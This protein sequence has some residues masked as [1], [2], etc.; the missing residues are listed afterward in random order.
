LFEENG[1][2]CADG[3]GGKLQ[4]AYVV[5]V[6]CN[7]G[8]GTALFGGGEEE[9]YFVVVVEKD[10]FFEV[11]GEGGGKVGRGKHASV[12][13]DDSVAEQFGAEVDE[14]AAAEA[15]DGGV[16]DDVALEVIVEEDLFD[17]AAGGAHAAGDSG[18]FECGTG[19]GG[20]GPALAVVGEYDFSV[21]ADVDHEGGTVECGELGGE[22]AGDG[23]AANE[24]ADDWENVGLGAWVDV[25]VEMADRL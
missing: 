3:G 2:A 8:V 16:V 12:W 19:G 13:G 24:A 9:F 10:A 18:A 5:L 11:L 25:D 23:V 14:A 1:D 17:G 21:G 20:C 22:E 7:W 6:E 15:E 4:F